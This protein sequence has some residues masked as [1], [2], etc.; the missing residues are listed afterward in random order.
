MQK[1]RDKQKI[2]LVQLCSQ[3]VFLILG[4]WATKCDFPRKLYKNRGLSIFS[5]RKKGK[6]N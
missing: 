1:K 3:I 4:G 2:Q 6:K 5:E